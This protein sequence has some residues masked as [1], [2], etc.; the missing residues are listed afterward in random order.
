MMKKRIIL[1]LLLLLALCLS[2]TFAACT[3]AQSDQTTGGDNPSV[4]NP[5]GEDPGDED[6]SDQEPDEENPDGEDPDGEDPD[7]PQE[8]PMIHDYK[9]V[10]GSFAANGTNAVQSKTNNA[11]AINKT[12]T[13]K[14]GSLEATL[15]LAGTASDNGIVFALTEGSASTYWENAGTSY[16]F[17]FVS[18]IGNAY[19]GRVLDGSWLM[20]AEKPISGFNASGTYRLRVERDTSGI[21]CYVNG[22]MYLYYT[23]TI[24]LSGNQYGLRAGTAGVSYTDVVAEEKSSEETQPSED[25]DI[26]TG[27]LTETEIGV[28]ATAATIALYKGLSFTEG[29]LTAG[30][31]PVNAKDNGIIFAAD[32]EA[33]SYYSFT[34]TAGRYME[35]AKVV[36][37]ERTV[38]Q[39]GVLSAGYNVTN[40]YPVTIVRDGNDIYCYLSYTSAQQICY[41]AYTDSEPLTGTR[42]GV[43]SGEAGAFFTDPAVSQETA[44]RTAKT[45]LFGHSY[46]E[47]WQNYKT[48]FYEYESIDNI[49]IGGSIAAHWKDLIA[50][51]VSYAPEL[52]VF[53]IGINDLSV[54]YTAAATAADTE[55][56]LLALHEQLP[57][58]EFVLVG[59]NHC[60]ARDYLATQISE[61]NKLFRNIAAK[62]DWLNYA[63]TEYLFCATD[64]DPSSTIDTDFTDGLHPTADAYK[65]LAESIRSAIA[66]EDQPEFDE[67]LAQQQ[68]AEAKAQKLQSIS[69]WSEHAFSA[70]NWTQ[71]KPLYDAAAA[72]IAACETQEDLNALDLSEEIAALKAIA[73]K[74]DAFIANAGDL[75]FGIR[76]DAD[77]WKKQENGSLLVNGCSYV[78]DDTVQGTDMEVV[79]RLDNNSGTVATGGFFLRASM[80]PN[81]G[82]DGYLVN[83]VSDLN[84]IQIYYLQNVYN[85]NSSSQI[86][87]YIGGWAYTGE[88][89]GTEFYVKIEGDALY[90]TTYETYRASGLSSAIV[91]DLT[92]NGAYAV[93]DAGYFGVIAWNTDVSYE[94]TISELVFKPVDDAIIAQQLAEAKAQKL[95]TISLWSEYAFTA[96]QWE[97]AQPLYEAAAAKI[98]ACK[99]VEEVTALNLSADVAAL[100]A[101]AN[102]ADAMTDDVVDQDFGIRLAAGNWKKQD[103]GALLLDG[104]SYVLDDSVQFAD[105]E[106]V[107][108]LDNNSG[109][110]GAGGVLLRAS[111]HANGGINGYLV[112]YVTD[113]NFIQIFYL[114]NAYA[115]SSEV[116]TYIGGWAY[117]GEVEGVDFYVKIEG[118]TLYLTTYA[119]YLATGLSS[120]IK[121]DLTYNGAYDLYDAGYFGVIAWNT[122]V[123]YEFT[124]SE[125][126]IEPVQSSAPDEPATSC[127]EHTDTNLDGKCD[128]CGENLPA[129][130]EPDEPEIQV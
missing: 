117:T 75:S 113:P 120:A 124:L 29:T 7:P 85:T 22:D 71:A 108:R 9:V 36:N 126:V 15:T 83:Y 56:V 16:Y 95:Q 86:L 27:G 94:F 107:F 72:K 84:Y 103:N 67:E 54:G 78:L 64:G 38:L 110:V 87:T 58:T 28:R 8:E 97:A 33:K 3:P 43:L 123:T 114:N 65:L 66:G 24:P 96:E 44:H 69:V 48:D 63:E 5:G 30:V 80:N 70:E 19:L 122:G 41:A 109:A 57:D 1:P 89:E 59:V 51:T 11:M 125:L 81:T 111:M 34:F 26:L 52:A 116:L 46:M 105:G 62:Y 118:G 98:E 99:T 100:E 17:Y 18:Q 50:Q 47:L 88:V 104:C 49:G 79:F 39:R 40:S 102:K 119:N 76:F 6:P 23:E 68:L 21:T 32:D 20:C 77:T 55:A 93:Y 37:G 25:Y 61:T 115:G 128:A 112:N 53:M 121:V 90:L 42:V 127:T 92:N 60:P 13:L 45:L 74:A 130:S 101:L 12:G 10:N 73:N 106:A 2:L 14:Y 4:E 31:V 82:V 129:G 91:V 35:L